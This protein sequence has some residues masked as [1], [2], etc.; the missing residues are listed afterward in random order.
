MYKFS[1]AFDRELEEALLTPPD[2]KKKHKTVEISKEETREL[3]EE[4]ERSGGSVSTSI[5][6]KRNKWKRSSSTPSP[7]SFSTP[8]L[9]AHLLHRPAPTHR[10]PGGTAGDGA[11]LLLSR[12]T[13]YCSTPGLGAPLLLSLPT[14]YCSIPGLGAHL[15]HRPSLM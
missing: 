5:R 8:S 13:S 14:S 11:P 10:R 7:S 4:E 2:K 9:G 1:R 12:P 15:L 3:L 6:L